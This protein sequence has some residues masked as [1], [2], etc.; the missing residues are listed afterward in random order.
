MHALLNK[1]PVR[2]ALAALALLSVIWGYNWVMMK[3]ALRDA[4][5]FDFAALRTLLGALSL[6][7][8]LVWLRRPLR[9]ADA[10]A[11]FLLGLLMGQE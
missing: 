8:L 1:H 6:F 11:V 7:V 4:G 10:R 9:P 5:A 3:L 2:S